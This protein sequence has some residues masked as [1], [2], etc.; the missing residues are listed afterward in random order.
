[1][2]IGRDAFQTFFDLLS[3]SAGPRLLR[4]KGLVHDRDE[5]ERPRVIHA[6]QHVIYPPAILDDWPSTISA[7]AS[8]SSQTALIRSRCG[9]SLKPP[10]TASRSRQDG[11]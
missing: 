2:L 3:T 9:S 11:R 6:V 1:M 7:P 5:P 8:S 10:S 4:V